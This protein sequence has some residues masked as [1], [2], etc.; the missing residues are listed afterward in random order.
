MYIFMIISRSFLLRKGNVSDKSCTGNDDTHSVY[1]NLF[2]RKMC[3]FEIMWKNTVEP[4]RP[5]M[6]I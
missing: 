2:L 6:T 1:S 4:T 3:L 5:Q